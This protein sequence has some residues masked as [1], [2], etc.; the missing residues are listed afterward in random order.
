[1]SGERLMLALVKNTL[2][3]MRVGWPLVQSY[4]DILAKK[5]HTLGCSW[6]CADVFAFW[7]RQACICSTKSMGSSRQA[8]NLI[9]GPFLN[10]TTK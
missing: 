5:Q 1:M 2:V 9:P 8:L 7:A 3:W 6:Y 4:E 10:R